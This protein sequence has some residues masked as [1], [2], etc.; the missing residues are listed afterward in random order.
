MLRLPRSVR[1]AFFLLHSLLLVLAV[2][3]AQAQ[4]LG[5]DHHSGISW[6]AISYL[7]GGG[8]IPFVDTVQ[9]PFPN[10]TLGTDLMNSGLTTAL[11]ADGN[12]NIYFAD[13][14]D[15]F[16]LYRNVASVPALLAAVTTKD[17][18]ATQPVLGAVYHVAGI[19]DSSCNSSTP[20]YC[21]DAS[22]AL[23][24][25]LGN[26]I[27][28]AI[29]STGNIYTAD[30][31]A[32]IAAIR[33]I[34]NMT[35]ADGSIDTAVTTFAGQL[36]LP[37]NPNN[38]SNNGE[39]GL[40]N[41]SSLFSAFSVKVDGSGNIY[42]ADGSYLLRVV[43]SGSSLPPILA[44]PGILPGGTTPQRDHIYSFAGSP[45]SY[46]SVPGP[47]VSQG[48]ANGIQ[49]NFNDLAVDANGNIFFSDLQSNIIDVLYTGGT[50]PPALSALVPGPLQAGNVYQIAGKQ[51]Q[52][53]VTAPCG[54]GM[55]ATQALID[56]F[57]LQLDPQ[58]NL[59][60][61][62]LGDATLR[63]IDTSGYISSKLGVSTPGG[64]PFTGLGGPAV[65]ET[66]GA[67]SF[68]IDSSNNLFFAAGGFILQALPVKAQ[69]V[70]FPQPT[71]VTYGAGPITLYA[72]G[73]DPVTQADTY[74]A[75]TYAV[76]SGPGQISGNSLIVTGAGTIQVTAS[77]AGSTAYSAASASVSVTVAQAVLTVRANDDTRFFNTANPAFTASYTG[78]ENGDTVQLAVSGVPQ[79]TTTAIDGSGGATNQGSAPGQYPITASAGSLTSTNYSLQ[80]VPGTLFITGVQPQ[81]ITFNPLPPTTY[82]QTTVVQLSA[83]AS[84]GLLP[85]FTLGANSPAVI[86]GSVL[87][88]T[89]AGTVS[90]TA[91]QLGGGIYK[92]AQP[93]TQSFTVAPAQLTVTG[94]AVTL[95]Y[96]TAVNVAQFPLP[97]ITGLVGGDMQSILTGAAAYTTTATG[98]P[99]AGNNFLIQVALGS[100]QLIPSAARN[101]TLANFVPGSLTIVKASQTISFDPIS[102]KAY[103]LGL[104]LNVISRDAAGNPTGQPVTVN[105][106]RLVLLFGFGQLLNSTVGPATIGFNAVGPLTVTAVQAGSSDYTAAAPVAQSINVAKAPLNIAALSISRGVGDPNPVFTFVYGCSAGPGGIGC[107]VI[108]DSA[109]PNVLSGLPILTTPADMNS[110]A[111]T[112]PIVV[113]VSQ[114]QSANYYLVPINATLTVTDAGSY[115]FVA[116]DPAITVPAGQARQTTLTLTSINLFQGM[117]TMSCGNLPANV[118]CIFSPATFTF[119]GADNNN[120][121]NNAAGTLT[122]TTLGGQAVVGQVRRGVAS[123]GIALAFLLPGLGIFFASRSRSLTYRNRL[124]GMLLLFTLS[125]APLLLSGCGSGGSSTGTKFAAP[126]TYNVN[127]IATGTPTNGSA[128]ILK[129]YMLTLVVQ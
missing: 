30:G 84:S 59:Y 53:C 22:T 14:P 46:C 106:S 128:Q 82:G 33:R 21:K 5:P 17:S 118:S 67:N 64:A 63:E 71:A 115:S 19:P 102:D 7:V 68:A 107:F 96:G 127:V 120:M 101:Y 26:V 98:T 90:V 121:A 97:T 74:L 15:V 123:D 117:V 66:G 126:G 8:T 93:V 12:G 79:L 27:A 42:I 40:A 36:N 114:I 81:T 124:L 113:D 29:D 52:S 10:G 9:T 45:G 65:Q 3:P 87:T 75:V 110:P 56:P 37:T 39:G 55:A 57:N 99:H 47:C 31:G 4:T 77:V 85:S 103:G 86:A 129:T 112:Y 61:N 24:A 60:F 95:P 13:G 20:S 25:T 109:T 83:T 34:N 100:L 16:I 1:S 44:V 28:M 89:G 119:T 70:N 43:Y 32:N 104:P 111:G 72:V 73:Q 38:F 62:D 125:M 41:A 76:T 11:A 122:I 88:I 108:G 18:P 92:G 2:S 48:P 91:N 6:G 49:V 94:P 69:T 35:H 54:D 80:F 58:G 78:L 105:F 51:F 50:Q 23:A 116:S